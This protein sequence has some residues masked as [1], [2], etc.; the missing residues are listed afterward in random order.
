MACSNPADPAGDR[1]AV[2]G[3]C[4]EVAVTHVLLPYPPSAN[5]LW[6]VF[7]GRVV[8]SAIATAYKATAAV[9]ARKAG[10]RLSTGPVE[11][12]VIVHP[13]A[14]K[15]ETGKP[16]RCIDTSNALKCAEDALQGV[17]YVN[18][19]QVVSIRARRGDPVPQG[20]L[21]VEVRRAEQVTEAL[22]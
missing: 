11:L 2:P 18:D 10:M 5:R 16:H 9:L 3:A 17:G 14:R 7:R 1:A 19:S 15:R 21:S 22:R 12:V 4:N 6:R 8:S 13:K 20:A